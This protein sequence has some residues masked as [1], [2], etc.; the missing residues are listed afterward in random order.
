MTK[1]VRVRFAPSPTGFLHVGSARTALFSYFYAKRFGGTF[2]LRI[3]DTDLERSKKEFE[4]E[5]IQ[6]M[7]WLGLTSDEGP[8]YQTKRFDLYRSYVAKM[9]E[10][11][12]AYKCYCT[13]AELDE[14]RTK[15]Q[16]EGRKPMYDRR[17]RP[18][19]G[20]TLPP[21]PAGLEAVVR[22]KAPLTGVTVVHD[23]IHGEVTFPNE[24]M[25]DFIILRTNNAPTYNFTVVV[26]DV[27]MKIS[28]VIRG[29]D[30]LSNTPKQLL[31]IQALGEQ[32]PIYAHIPMILAPDKSKLSKRHGAVAVSQYKSEGIL[33]EAFVSYLMKLGWSH[34]DQEVFSREELSKFFDLGECGKSG[35][36]FDRAKLEWT[37][38]HFIK[39]LEP[40]YIAQCTKE[41]TGV[42]LSP[43]LSTEIGRQ[44]FKAAADRATKLQD[45]VTALGWYLHDEIKPDAQAI[46]TVLKPARTDALDA[47]R[48]ALKELP[49]WT[50][51]D[52]APVFKKVATDLGLKMP[53]IAKPA[54]IL[55][56]GTMAS[57]DIGLVVAALGRE[58]ADARLAAKDRIV[59]T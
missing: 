54:R 12:Q 25:D 8:F 22:F 5:I 11:G 58:R 35:S 24:E 9:L 52:I 56:T 53:D 4:D 15:A 39:T 51:Q 21:V 6:S 33:P 20:K 23:A 29:D 42:D 14:M 55:L 43:M 3:E 17:W 36:V 48:K 37:N 28:H 16:G 2:I 57:P 31:L 30:H 32:P 50:A 38:A 46:E 7:A 41:I 34:G 1:P 47:L 45:L 59:G 19:I 13:P 49:S 40:Q 18:E 26:D 44:L 27:D 10:R